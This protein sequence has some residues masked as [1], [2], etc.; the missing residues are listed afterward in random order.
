MKRLMRA[1]FLSF[2]LVMTMTGCAFGFS[3]DRLIK[4]ELTI[5]NNTIK[6]ESRVNGTY[7][8]KKTQEKKNP[9]EKY[10]EILK[11][12]ASETVK[13]VAEEAGKAAAKVVIDAAKKAAIKDEDED[14][15]KSDLEI[16]DASEDQIEPI[17]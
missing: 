9:D 14:E 17:D 5:L 4:F 7:S 8:E 16:E 3:G 1:L 11:E 12:S 10:Q 2:F 6:W 13:N 15:S